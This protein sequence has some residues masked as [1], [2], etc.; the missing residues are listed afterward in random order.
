[1][2][3]GPERDL[4]LLA[5]YIG[6]FCKKRGNPDYLSIVTFNRPSLGDDSIGITIGQTEGSITPAVYYFRDGTKR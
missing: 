3:N 5:K 6:N 2:N 4:E 1:M